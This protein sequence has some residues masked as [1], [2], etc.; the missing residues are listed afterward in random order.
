M[1]HSM[2]E[3]NKVLLDWSIIISIYCIMAYDYRLWQKFK[4]IMNRDPKIRPDTMCDLNDKI[5]YLEQREG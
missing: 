3:E 2:G 1:L 5:V 4:D